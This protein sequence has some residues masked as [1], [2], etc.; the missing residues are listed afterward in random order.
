MSTIGT[1]TVTVSPEIETEELL[2]VTSVALVANT[3][4]WRKVVKDLIGDEPV[5]YAEKSKKDTLRRFPIV[6]IM[7]TDKEALDRVLTKAA[8]VE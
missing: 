7:S 1:A 4:N 8:E 6:T 3:S 5:T 2:H